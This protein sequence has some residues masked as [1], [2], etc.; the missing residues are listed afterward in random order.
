MTDTIRWGVLGTGRI[1]TR[2]VI[3]AMQ[4]GAHSVVAAL[5]TESVG[6][7]A[8][9]RSFINRNIVFTKL[10]PKKLYTQDV[11]ITIVER[12]FAN[13]ISSPRNLLSP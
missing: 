5:A 8:V 2:K 9:P 13:T 6:Q 7:S 12:C 4:R 11:L 1:G 3:P 10:W